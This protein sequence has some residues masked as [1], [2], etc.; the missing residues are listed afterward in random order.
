MAVIKF[1]SE[2]ADALIRDLK[3]ISSDIDSNMRKV[4]SN[5]YGKEINLN[6]SRLKVYDY[7][8]KTVDVEQEDG[9]IVQEV[10]RERYLKHNFVANARTYNQHVRNL[11]KK[12]NSAKK[13]AS[14][15]IES[16]INSLNKIK[17]LISEFETEQNLRL[18]NNMDGVGQFDFN[19]LSAY[20]PM[21]RPQNY[22]PSMG[23]VVVDEAYTSLHLGILGQRPTSINLE[24]LPI[25]DG[26]I[27]IA[28]NNGLSYQEKF[29]SI[30]DL[31]MDNV[32][33]VDPELM[34]EKTKLA[35]E[36]MIGIVDSDDIKI[37]DNLRIETLVKLGVPVIQ[38]LV[39]SDLAINLEN[40]DG[41]FDRTLAIGGVLLAS[42]G[43]EH[44]GEMITNMDL[45]RDGRKDFDLDHDGKVELPVVRDRID[46]QLGIDSDVDLDRGSDGHGHS[47]ENRQQGGYGSDVGRGTGNPSNNGNNSYNRGNQTQHQTQ[48]PETPP[49]AQE[50]N[51]PAT[52]PADRGQTNSKP[53]EAPKV[54]KGDQR[55]VIDTPKTDVK[56]ESLPANNDVIDAKEVSKVDAGIEPSS[57]DVAIDQEIQAT[58][59]TGEYK[60]TS[61]GTSSNASAVDI[62]LDDNIEK[63]GAGV[64]AGAAGIGALSNMGGNSGAANVPQVNGMAAGEILGINNSSGSAS[65]GM[66]MG[67]ATNSSASTGTVNTGNSGPAS[68]GGE[69]TSDRGSISSNN[70]NNKSSNT[71]ASGRGG[72]TLED[73]DGNKNENSYGKPNKPGENEDTTKKGML[74]DASIAELEAKDEKQ[75]KVATGVTAGTVVLSGILSIANVFPWIMIILALIAIG[76]YAAYRVKK[77]KDKEKRRAALAA[78]KAQEEANAT[79]TMEAVQNVSDTVVEQVATEVVE[80]PVVAENTTS[81]VPSNGGEFSEQPY[82][83]SR[84]GVTE[85]AINTTQD[86]EK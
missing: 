20:G 31:L 17:A 8:N 26:M 79:V 41:A 49:R 60:D 15:S 29:D 57:K 22:S 67:D 38:D 53:L 82:E 81:E 68:V 80:T 52:P 71:S 85:I 23:T 32:L 10:K 24:R 76:T 43:T 45:N 56:T 9:T 5:S 55:P 74:G 50:V 30:K 47:S 69:S 46:S 78:K 18:T 61:I 73:K 33:E 19:F 66:M 27:D 21:G 62:K 25:F 48:T 7:R 54:D 12:S 6:D 59:I 75:I 42:G 64:L 39:G 11:Y 34:N 4:Y 37:D 63:K 77:K 72:S 65:M 86:I 13:K 84:D 35:L 36:S 2:K 14:K 83:P 40:V 44:V 1:D 28:K 51:R 3:K 58:K 70:S 16:V